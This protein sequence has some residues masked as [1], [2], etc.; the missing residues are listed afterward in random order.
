MKT[1]KKLLP[2]AI[3]L[4]AAAAPALAEVSANITATSNYVWRGVSQTGNDAAVQGGVDWASDSGIY[5][6]TWVSTL[7]GGEPSSET[8]FYAGWAADLGDS[9]LGIDLGYI[10]YAYL[11]N[12]NEN[13]FGEI[14]ANIS[15]SIF[16]AGVSVTTNTGDDNEDSTFDQG[17]VYVWVAGS[18]DLGNDWSLGATIGAYEFT[19]D[20]DTGVGDVSYQHGQLDLT[21]SAGDFGDVT[22]S[23]SYANEEAQNADDDVITFVSWSKGF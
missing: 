12:P 8:D 2:V 6:G 19:N 18:F 7:G 3:A 13:D 11:D 23:L 21:K 4:S 22:L 20:G 15:F 16:S 10:Y 5:A 14:Y 9:G 1:M 17:D